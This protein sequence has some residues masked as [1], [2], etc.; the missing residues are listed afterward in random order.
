[1]TLRLVVYDETDTGP[2][3]VP[4]IERA[5]DGTARGTGGLTRYWRAGGLLHRGVGRAAGAFGATAW[6]EAIAWAVDR[7]ERRGEPI[8]ELQAWGHGGWG[9]MQMGRANG[10]APLHR[11]DRAALAR[12]SALAP[13]L[14]RL[15]DALA[16]GAL[17]WLRCC[18]A[19]GTQAGRD[20]AAALADRLERRVA[21]HTFIIGAW[22]SGTSSL[23]PGTAPTWS[24]EEGV[25]M[26]GG[27]PR[28][29]R[30][31]TYDAPRTV[32]F[33]TLGLPSGL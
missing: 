2:I 9:F 13:S 3:A 5:P 7:A 14:D 31:S 1:M 22:Q 6:S 29:A 15:R 12:G 21:G 19:F 28:G 4:R 26:A 20:F 17:V 32:T 30:V 18:S 8:A 11:L 23:E 27:A 16:P 33:L 25:D 10:A 24:A